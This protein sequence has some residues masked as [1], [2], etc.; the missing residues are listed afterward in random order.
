MNETSQ[1]KTAKSP[2][3]DPVKGKKRDRSASEGKLLKAAEDVFS[4]H[5]FK[6]ATTRM[7]AKKA[8]INES[9][10]GRY[11]DGKMGL[12][13]AIIENYVT[14]EGAHPKLTYPAQATLT[15]EILA[16]AQFKFDR[17]CK[18][19][20]DFFK[21]VLS[22]AIVDAKFAKRIREIMQPFFQPE[23]EER[24]QKLKDTGKIHSDIDV[25]TLIKGLDIFMFGNIIFQR[26]L[27]GNTLEETGKTLE[28][29][30]RRHAKALET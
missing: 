11:F 20:F 13:V 10:I 21:I 16:Y 18:K 29:F 27:L 25:K 14:V 4:K 22:Q 3:K 6:G 15:D 8:G 2:E 9:L 26:V 5:G 7:I 17:D 19:N 24:L 30:I 1:N 23:L 28:E 12:L